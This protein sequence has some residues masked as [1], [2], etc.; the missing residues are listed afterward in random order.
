MEQTII[1]NTQ[2]SHLNTKII[3]MKKSFFLPILLLPLIGLG[4]WQADMTNSMQ[5]TVQEYKV[6]S[7]GSQYRY[8]YAAD[9]TGILI[10]R[11]EANQTVIMI[12]EEKIVHYTTTDGMMSRMN[13]PAQAYAGYLA[14]GEEKTEGRETVSGYD[15]IKK[16]IYKDDKPVI[17]MWF[18]EELNFPVKMENHYSVNTYMILE[19]IE[20]WEHD[21]SLF[22]VPEG[23]TEV[24]EDMNPVDR[25]P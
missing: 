5:G 6:H 18:S 24:D 1:L 25:K 4:Q 20:P 22:M 11:P 17:S 13:D 10:V 7:D 23:L 16:V 12:M 8:D 9:I 19:N 14:Y 2:Y 3:S 15:C 21:P